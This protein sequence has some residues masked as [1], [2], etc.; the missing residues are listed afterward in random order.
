MAFDIDAP[1][2]CVFR[3]MQTPRACLL[4]LLVGGGVVESDGVVLR[5]DAGGRAVCLREMGSCGYEEAQR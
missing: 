1:I 2:L 3:Y 4:G 5:L